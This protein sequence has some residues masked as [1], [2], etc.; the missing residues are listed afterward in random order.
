MTYLEASF[1]EPLRL[2]TGRLAVVSGAVFEGGVLGALLCAVLC[3]CQLLADNISWKRKY[4]LILGRSFGDGSANVSGIG[5]ESF[6]TEVSL[7]L[8]QVR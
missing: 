1:S 4:L 2:F 8:A 5:C 7:T 6:E 3:S